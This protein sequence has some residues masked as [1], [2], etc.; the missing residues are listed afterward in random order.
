MHRLVWILQVVLGLYFVVTGVLHFVVPDGLPAQLEWMYE[1]PTW[2]HWVSGAA[3]IAGGLGLVLPGLTGIRTE[4]VP[5]A[6][7][8]L[9]AIMLMAA[10]WH[11]SRG[12]AQNIVANLVVAALLAFVGWVRW[13]VHPLE[14]H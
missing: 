12:E 13:R 8:G 1:L 10:V 7:L 11:A 5:L 6:A 14:A 2:A 3:E 4:L 9:L